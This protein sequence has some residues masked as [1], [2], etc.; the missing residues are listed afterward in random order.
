[1]LSGRLRDLGVDQLTEHSLEKV[2]VGIELTAGV[3]AEPSGD[4]AHGKSEDGGA[5]QPFDLGDIL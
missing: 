1:M 5:D 2:E 4:F 3:V